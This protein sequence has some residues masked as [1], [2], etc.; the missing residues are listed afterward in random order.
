MF[1]PEEYEFYNIQLDR[2]LNGEIV[3]NDV[4]CKAEEMDP[5]SYWDDGEDAVF[6]EFTNVTI[7]NST[8]PK[9]DYYIDIFPDHI[10][11]EYSGNT[12]NPSELSRVLRTELFSTE[13]DEEFFQVGTIQDLAF[14]EET[15]L[16]KFI[17]LSLMARTNLNN[18]ES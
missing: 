9:M 10:D 8:D 1:T 11:F 17:K 16:R 18:R 15:L 12:G 5:V 14:M 4:L 3:L 7:Y 6:G 2:S 13:S